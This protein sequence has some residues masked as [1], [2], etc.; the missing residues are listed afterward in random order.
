[1]PELTTFEQINADAH[2]GLE[3]MFAEVL[4]SALEDAACGRDFSEK[5]ARLIKAFNG[6]SQSAHRLLIKV[7][8]LEGMTD[9]DRV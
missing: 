1:M 9:A 4:R 2:A 3:N 8:E 7:R 6:Q 5:E